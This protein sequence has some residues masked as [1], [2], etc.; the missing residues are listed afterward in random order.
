M[1]FE[2]TQ[3]AAALNGH[4]AARRFFS[5]CFGLAAANRERL[6]VAHV[7]SAARCLHLECYE[8]DSATVGMPVR[9][10]MVDAAR[11]GSAGVMLAHNHPSGDSSPSRE[12]CA[13]TRKLAR[14]GEAIDLAI[15]DHLVFAGGSC[16]SMRRLGLL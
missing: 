15:L 3:P 12:D 11:L 13:A 5:S 14:A 10:I 1:H 8:G 16:S 7:D 6:W 4:D 9:D 2:R